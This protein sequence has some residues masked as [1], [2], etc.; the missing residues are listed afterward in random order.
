MLQ[1]KVPTGDEGYNHE[2]KEFVPLAWFELEMEH[3]LC[4][5]SKWESFFKRPFLSKA[6]KT[7]E[8][9]LWYIEAMTLTPNVP[10][11]VFQN[12]SQDNIAEINNYITDLMTATTI[13][14]VDTGSSYK[15]VTAELI[16]YWMV[17]LNIP[18]EC[19]H[20]HLNRLFALIRVCNEMNGPK[21]K[22]GRREAMDQQR[23]LNAE[24]R[25]RFG[26]SG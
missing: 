7:P 23:D 3:S 10:P 4:S 2:T 18:F 14:E 12:L 11:E 17:A 24:R 26:T 25:A 9:I 16:Y 15:I 6:E 13:K 1:I 8:E 21:K 22:M 5:L 20:W 19:Q